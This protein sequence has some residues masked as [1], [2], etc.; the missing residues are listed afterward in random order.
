MERSATL[1]RLAHD[2]INELHIYRVYLLGLDGW[3]A[4][5]ESFSAEADGQALAIA[6]SVMES[7]DDVFAGY[8]L[9]SGARRIQPRRQGASEAAGRD[10]RFNDAVQAHQDTIADLEERLERAF[11]CVR[12]SRKLVEAATLMRNQ[13][14]SRGGY[15]QATGPHA[16]QKV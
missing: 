16:A 6:R 2:C 13:R 3:I 4:A 7:T 5:A 14:A 8:E 1:M 10:R 11:A 12:R 9:W 15:G